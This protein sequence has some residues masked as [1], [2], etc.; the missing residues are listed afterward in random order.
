MTYVE[1]VK[2]Y[3]LR[4]R[5]REFKKF[6]VDDGGFSYRRSKNGV[7]QKIKVDKGTIA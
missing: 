4:E 2:D 5:S 1:K 3:K 7:I 6:C